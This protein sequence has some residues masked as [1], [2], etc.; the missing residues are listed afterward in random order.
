MMPDAYYNSDGWFS[1]LANHLW[2]KRSHANA[3]LIKHSIDISVHGSYREK[4]NKENGEVALGVRWARWR[5]RDRWKTKGKKV[6]SCVTNRGVHTF[7]TLKW[8]SLP[9]PSF[10]ATILTA[11][12]KQSQITIINATFKHTHMH[13]LFLLREV[14]TTYILNSHMHLK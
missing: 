13:V 4:S 7:D 8:F 10:Q 6:K 9:S 3:R 12:T 5:G 11:M 14:T 1:P 2:S